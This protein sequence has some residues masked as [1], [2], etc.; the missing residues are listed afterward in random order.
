MEAGTL[1]AVFAG[2][3]AGVAVISAGVSAVAAWRSRDAKRVAEKKRNEAV[4]AAQNVASGIDRLALVQ[5]SRQTAEASAQASSVVFVR[6][7]IQRGFSGWLVQNDSDRPVTN[8]A[9][10]STAGA[11]I[12]VYHGS[13]PDHLPE[14]VEHTVGA[15]QQ[16]RLTFR[17]AGSDS[18]H[19]DDSEAERMSLRFTD[20]R[21]QE[22]ER[23]G[24][25]GAQPVG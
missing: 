19:A 11:K 17:P 25:Q 20:A 24:S 13:G 9:V 12:V 1:S 16:S 2:V 21:G 10:R 22:W 8:V 5:E 4:E 6:S 23:I 7:E 14:Y 15:H 3:S 18:A